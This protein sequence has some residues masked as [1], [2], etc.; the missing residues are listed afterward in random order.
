MALEMTR[1][2][3]PSTVVFCDQESVQFFTANMRTGM[4]FQPFGADIAESVIAEVIA[5]DQKAQAIPASFGPK[6]FIK[7]RHLY[8]DDKNG[9]FTL[10]V[11]YL[12]DQAEPPMFT[13]VDIKVYLGDGAVKHHGQGQWVEVTIK[14]VL[15]SS[16]NFSPVGD[17]HYG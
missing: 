16:D 7:L 12:H 2:S 15:C 14:K 5:L 13:E 10:N 4:L 11:D 6:H 3:K 9:D 17:E 1:T 8:V